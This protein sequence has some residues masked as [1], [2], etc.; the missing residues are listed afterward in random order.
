MDDTYLLFY[1]KPKNKQRQIADVWLDGVNVAGFQSLSVDWAGGGL[2]S[3]LDDL[4]VFVRSLN[5][6]K[7]I[8]HDTLDSLYQFDHKYRR[9]IHY[10]NGFMA[11]HFK[12]F[13]PT[14]ASLPVMIGHMGILGTQM[15]YDKE[16]DTVFVASFGSS[17]YSAGS[18]RTMI[19]CLHYLQRYS[20]FV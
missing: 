7:I 17:D 2:I 1:S 13:F 9:G 6:G 8:S 18:V 11:Y 12:E 10:G 5:Q 3:T 16:S 14:L 20:R 4:A 15:F 19:K